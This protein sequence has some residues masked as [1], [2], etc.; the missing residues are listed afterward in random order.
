MPLEIEPITSAPSRADHTVPR[1]PNRLVPAITG[2][3]MASSSRSLAPELWLTASRRE[4][5][6]MPPIADIEPAM[7]NTATRTR[8]TRMPARRA[9]SSLPPT[10][11]T[12]R[13]NRVRVTTYCI[14]PTNAIRISIA[15]GR[16]RSALR[17][18]IAATTATATSTIRSSGP[19][20]C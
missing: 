3:A 16:P 1:P 18:A 2:P 9:A 19:L 14:P 13:P 10:A 17:I 20:S 12:W 6:R 8:L 5:A 11:N 7:A 4:A 15:R